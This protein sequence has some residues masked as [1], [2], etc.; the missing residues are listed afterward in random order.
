MRTLH[1]GHKKPYHTLFTLVL[2]GCR[3]FFIQAIH[4]MLMPSF[5]AV[6]FFR[7][8]MYTRCGFVTKLTSSA[9]MRIEVSSG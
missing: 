5:F 1:I 7:Y 8:L 3:S 2:N 6:P 9:V 4:V